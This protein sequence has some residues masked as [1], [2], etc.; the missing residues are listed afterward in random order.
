MNNFK[1]HE[2]KNNINAG[3]ANAGIGWDEEMMY[4]KLAKVVKPAR[5]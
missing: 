5:A 1:D 3:N 4:K 2:Y